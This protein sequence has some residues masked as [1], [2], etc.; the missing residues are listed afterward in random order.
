MAMFIILEVSVE[1][2]L[3]CPNQ[4]KCSHKMKYFFAEY[5]FNKSTDVTLA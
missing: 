3:N 5:F 2:L 1:R 4:I